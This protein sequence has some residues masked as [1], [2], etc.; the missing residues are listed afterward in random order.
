MAAGSHKEGQPRRRF[1]KDKNGSL[2]FDKPGE[3]YDL[4]KF[5]PLEVK[6]SLCTR[7]PAL[8]FW[9]PSFQEQGCCGALYGCSVMLCYDMA[10]DLGVFQ[11]DQ[12]L[13][14]LISI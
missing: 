14:R 5:E 3:E 6:V 1:L 4:S 11:W 7:C 8:L 12:C 2:V 13:D 9:R 10:S